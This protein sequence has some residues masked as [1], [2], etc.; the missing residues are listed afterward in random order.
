MEEKKK[1]SASL[2]QYALDSSQE[3]SSR[4]LLLQVF[5]KREREKKGRKRKERR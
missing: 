1:S 4:A 2:A 3:A 5:Q